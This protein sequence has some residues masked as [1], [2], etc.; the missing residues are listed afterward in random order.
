[1]FHTEVP[2][3]QTERDMDEMEMWLVANVHGEWR[4]HGK[5]VWFSSGKDAVLFKLTWGGQ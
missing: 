5:G 4:I 1:M 3:I 2:R